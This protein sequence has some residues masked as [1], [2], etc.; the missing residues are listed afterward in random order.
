MK[1][2]RVLKIAELLREEISK[3]ILNEMNDPTARQASVT[4]VLVSP[5][6]KIAKIYLNIL[7]ETSARDSILQAI[8]RAKSF[9]RHRV[10]QNVELRYVPELRFFYD[11]TLDY[12]AS[13]E[14]LIKKANE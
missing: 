10:G 13:I 2:T 1:S 5:D 9:I 7:G 11:D 14:E 12:V 6:L 4:R 8:D 3:I